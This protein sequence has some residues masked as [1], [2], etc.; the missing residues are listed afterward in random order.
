M[1]NVK[2]MRIIILLFLLLALNLPAVYGQTT[3]PRLEGTSWQGNTE[4]DLDTGD[5]MNIEFTYIFSKNGKVELAFLAFIS[6]LDY[7]R[8]PYDNT[9]RP[10]FNPMKSTFSG[11]EVCTYKTAGKSIQINCATTGDVNAIMDGNR[12]KGGIMS[13]LKGVNGKK[14]TWIIERMLDESSSVNESKFSA[15]VNSPLIGS[16]KYVEYGYYDSPVTGRKSSYVKRTLIVTYY[17]NGINETKLEAGYQSITVKR[18]WKYIP[19]G[20]SSGIAEEY[21]GDKLTER[22]DV[23]WI[24]SNQFEYTVTFHQNPELVGDKLIFT[25][26]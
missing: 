6:G 20:A 18:N 22:G 2:W 8:N 23:R 7:Q 15:P 19:K 21:Q 1:N 24:N 11:S 25:R 26:Q 3:A 13:K 12:M 9:I 10:V 14:E 4:F 17:Q 5:I 16:W